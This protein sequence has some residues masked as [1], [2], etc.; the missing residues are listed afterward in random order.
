DAQLGKLRG[1]QKNLARAVA[2]AAGDIPELVAEM[3]RRTE[4]I[5]RLEA[6]LA[7]AQRTPAIRAEMV[8]QAEAAV[9]TQ[10]ESL[11]AALRGESDAIRGALHAIFPDGVTLRAVKVPGAR[12]GKTRQ[13]FQVEGPAG[14]N[15]TSDPTG[16]F[17]KVTL[18]P[19]FAVVTK[20]PA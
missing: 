19:R 6:D 2:M 15:L 14:F 1:E 10:L 4:Q 3:G 9:R 18:R 5:R 8:A 16:V 11:R 20:R 13:V 17:A 7:V 12:K